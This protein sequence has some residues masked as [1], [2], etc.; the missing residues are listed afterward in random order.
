MPAAFRPSAPTSA[1]RTPS[2]AQAVALLCGLVLVAAGIAV[3]SYLVKPAK[4]RSFDLFYGSVY[5]NDN[6]SPGRHRPGQRQADRAAARRL[7]GRVGA[8]TGDNIDVYPLGG[9]NT[10]LLDPTTG[11][12]NMVDS[13]GFVVKTTD[14]GVPLPRSASTRDLDG[15][16]VRVVGL[17]RAPQPATH[18]GLS[19]QHGDGLGGGRRPRAGKGAGLRDAERRRCRTIPCPAAGANGDLWLLTGTGT[20]HQRDHPAQRARAAA[21]PG[22]TLTR[23]HGTVT[24]PAAVGS[25][26]GNADGTGGDVRRRRPR[27][28]DAGVPRRRSGRR[29]GVGRAGRRPDP[30]RRPTPRARSCSSTTRPTG[31]AGSACPP[32]HGVEPHGQQALRH[33]ADAQLV[34]PAQSN[35]RTYT[36][37]THQ[38]GALWQIDADG[39]ARPVPGARTYPL[40]DSERPD[41]RR[42]AGARRRRAGHLQR[43]RTCDAEVVFTDGSHAP[44]AIYKH[45]AVQ[46]DPSGATALADAHA[47]GKTNTGK[48][49]QAAEDRQASAADDQRQDQLQG[50]QAGPAHPDA[51][52]RRPCGR[53][54]SA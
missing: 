16:R 50:R 46:V 2:R 1:G 33:P 19:G 18:L 13:T 53:A 14:G 44:R 36:M 42:C 41:V 38:R 34:A 17:H 6:T 15:G 24:G 43:R 39:T 12:F 9:G 5:I 32:R 25:A 26:T 31:G 35:G 30:A 10:L 40:K 22:V 51:D 20:G 4:A 52:R 3:A 54:R 28:L 23:R 47:T 7:H 29:A 49:A 8:K 48:I 37:D 11:E 45:S 21:T 27:R